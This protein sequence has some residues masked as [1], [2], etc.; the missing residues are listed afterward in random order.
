V[1]REHPVYLEVGSKRVFA[2]AVEW[3]GW[4][5][6]G[7]DEEGALEA[8][9]AYGRRYKAA[10]G[11]AGRGFSAPKDASLFQV[12]ERLKGNA[13]T[14]FGVPGTPP[15]SDDR[16]VD[17][18]EGRRLAGLLEA[19]WATLDRTA[20]AAVG[21][22]L[23]KGPRGGGRDLDQIVRH[24]LEAE[25]GYLPKIGGRYRTPEGEDIADHSEEVREV[26]LEAVSARARGDRM[27]P[28]RGSTW[29]LRYFV[30]RDAWH[31]LDHAWEIEDRAA[32]DPA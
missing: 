30:R 1:A 13:S 10:V 25:T 26:A 15:A 18:A 29:A 31:V 22:S 16:P 27:P 14:D 23:R 6:S 7:R 17:R 12:V 21:I 32:P 3:P 28:T 4:C 11:S 19:C 9:A 24:V 2:G 8:L 20:E 5:R